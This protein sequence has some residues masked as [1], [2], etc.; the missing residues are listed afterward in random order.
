MRYSDIRTG[1]SEIRMRHSYIRMRYSD[2]RMGHS[3]IRMWHSDIRMRHSEIRMQHFFYGYGIQHG[4]R[5]V[6]LGRPTLIIVLSKEVPIR[7][8]FDYC[9]PGLNRFWLLVFNIV[10]MKSI[11]PRRPFSWRPTDFNICRIDWRTSCREKLFVLTAMR[12][13][14]W[15]DAARS[16]SQLPSGQLD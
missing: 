15:I 8:P 13:A 3:Y 7:V 12:I 2:I 1:H 10:A 16:S 9:P 6:F 11:Y 4:I 5:H 14:N